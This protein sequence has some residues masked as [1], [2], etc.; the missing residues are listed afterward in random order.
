M[1][2]VAI[3]ALAGVVI[4]ALYAV[5]A[6]LPALPSSIF[7]VINYCMGYFAQGAA[8]LYSFTYPAVIKALITVTV[9]VEAVVYGY[10]FVMWIAK[11][12]PMFG[13]SD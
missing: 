9:A 10:R 6:S 8:F 11:K 3:I 1:I 7:T 2:I 13:V 12:I 5:L 4:L